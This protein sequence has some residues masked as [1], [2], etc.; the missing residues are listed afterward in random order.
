MGTLRGTDRKNKDVLASLDVQ[1]YF[2][3]KVGKRKYERGQAF[4][5]AV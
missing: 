5:R 2:H 4:G 1:R 3:R